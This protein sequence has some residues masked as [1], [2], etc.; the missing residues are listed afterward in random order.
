MSVFSYL[1]A[2][3]VFFCPFGGYGGWEDEGQQ[4][5]PVVEFVEPVEAATLTEALTYGSIQVKASDPDAG[6][7]NGAGIDSVEMIIIDTATDTVVAARSEYWPTY[8]FGPDLPDGD[9]ELVAT[10]HSSWWAGGTSSTVSIMITI[11]TTL[12][13]PVT[14]QPP[15]TEPVTTQPPTTEPVTTQPP[16]TEPVTTQPPTTEPVTTQPPTTEPVTTTEPSTTQP[17]AGDSDRANARSLAL[18]NELRVQQGLGTLASDATMAAFAQDW[19]LTMRQTGFR[20]SGGPYGENIVWYSDDSMTAEQAAERFHESWMN[21]PGHYANMTS[22]QWTL[23][24]VGLYHDESGWWGTH[25][26]R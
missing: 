16:T 18:L 14:T 20:H 3:L 21:S 9:Y 11:D 4:S 12:D 2:A 25:V 22:P 5:H 1:F 23:V 13:E 24:G 7:Q 8:D 10:A 15:T 26:F 6:T 19:S 17:S